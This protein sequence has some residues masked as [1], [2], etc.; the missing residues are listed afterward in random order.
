MV[1]YESTFICSPEL[2]AEQVEELIAKAKKVIE[3]SKGSVLLVQQLGK[4]KLAYTINK[5]REGTYVYFEL[6][7]TGEMV[8]S[9]ENFYKVNDSIIRYLTVKTEKKK[10]PAKPAKAGNKPEQGSEEGT[11]DGSNKPETSGTE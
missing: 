9:L 6:S 5:F 3:T 8:S 1:A 7:G 11:R 2:P 4:K 10:A